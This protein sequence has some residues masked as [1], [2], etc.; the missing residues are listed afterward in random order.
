MKTVIPY[1]KKDEHI[2]RLL[3]RTMEARQWPMGKVICLRT[4]KAEPQ[5]LLERRFGVTSAFLPFPVHG[6][7]AAPNA[8][9]VHAATVLSPDEDFLFM[10]TDCLVLADY[11]E[12]E[13]VC[14]HLIEGRHRDDYIIAASIYLREIGWTHNGNAIYSPG[15]A[16]AMAPLVGHGPFDH[17]LRELALPRIIPTPL[18]EHTNQI[19]P[20]VIIS[21]GHSNPLDHRAALNEALSVRARI[22]A[23]VEERTY[24]TPMEQSKYR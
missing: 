19:R 9:F 16:Q 17:C 20:H 7:P 23:G 1:Y 24:P 14:D 18:F 5:E 15:A 10:E 4:D 21:H 2:L 3:L 11:Q 13:V 8:A 6:H 22:A 12:L